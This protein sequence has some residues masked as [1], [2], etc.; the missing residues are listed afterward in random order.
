VFPPS[1]VGVPEKP[2]ITVYIKIGFAGNKFM[3]RFRGKG[4]ERGKGKKT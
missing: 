2:S 1:P 3:T 4:N